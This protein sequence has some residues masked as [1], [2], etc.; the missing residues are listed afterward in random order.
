M[1]AD[2]RY[3]VCSVKP[4]P[5]SWRL[6]GSETGNVEI[7]I[8]SHRSDAFVI[9]RWYRNAMATSWDGIST[10]RDC[11]TL[12]THEPEK[13]PVGGKR[14]DNISEQKQSRIANEN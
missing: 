5:K 3:L 13:P 7:D 8:D 9:D 1:N 12:K 10:S 14:F 2:P 6:I 4:G 11:I